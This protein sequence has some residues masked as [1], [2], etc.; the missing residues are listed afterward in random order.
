ML[1]CMETQL[2]LM[3]IGPSGQSKRVERAN[4]AFSVVRELLRQ[5]C[6]AE[7][8]WALISEVLSDSMRPLALWCESA[9]LKFSWADKILKLNDVRLGGRNWVSFLQ[10]LQSSAA[11]PDVA[12]KFAKS[13]RAGVSLEL[14]ERIDNI[15]LD[16]VCLHLSERLGLETVN[17]VRLQNLPPAARS[18]DIVLP[19]STGSVPFLVSYH[20]AE[21]DDLGNFVTSKGTVLTKADELVYSADVLRQPAIIGFDRTYCC[22]EGSPSGWIE[23][24]SFDGLDA[25]R[26]NIEDIRLS[27]AEARLINRISGHVIG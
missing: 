25:A 6:P 18:G 14:G 10:R 13:L 15:N 19:S 20:D 16:S 11:T 3:I 2:G 1:S 27:G 22:Y 12:M 23:D 4:P 9:G 24:A 8:T 7:Q 21:I 17:L 26:K 5:T